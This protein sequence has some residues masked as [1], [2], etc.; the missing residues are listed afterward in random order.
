MGPL[1]DVWKK[2]KEWK[3]EKLSFVEIQKERHTEKIAVQN[4]IQSFGLEMLPDKRKMSYP[5]S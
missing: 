2:E 1:P 3:E 5:L 4:D